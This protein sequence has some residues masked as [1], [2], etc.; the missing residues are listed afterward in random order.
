[1]LPDIAGVE[2]AALYR[3]AGEGIDVGGDFYDL[4]NVAGDD[5]IAV[6]GDVCGKGPEA[7]AVTALARYT[8]RSAAVR[9][10]SP[11]SILEWLNDAMCRHD[12]NGR[13]CTIACVHLDTSR[14]VIRV[15]VACGGHPPA[16]LRRVDGTV[17]ELGSPGTLL[18]LVRDPQLQDQHSE[19][20]PG[21]A[22]V[23][24]TDG[25]TEARA[26]RPLAPAALAE[27][28]QP[29]LERGP[30][31]IARRAVALAEEQAGGALRDDVA[32]LVLRLTER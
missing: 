11:A 17:E 10:R 14:P 13:F 3:A 21:D 24:Y 7:A 22:L 26:D 27:A 2:A 29:V 6:I 31:A 32:V 12:L 9:R 15:V 18:G 5:W 16:L 19:L 4:F 1:V 30:G 25:I 23:L 8:I 20:H 28:L